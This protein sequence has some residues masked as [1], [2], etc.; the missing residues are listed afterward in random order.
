[1]DSLQTT[2]NSNSLIIKQ[3]TITAHRLLLFF[4]NDNKNN[5]NK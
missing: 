5:R 4:R 2:Q 1:M 3:K